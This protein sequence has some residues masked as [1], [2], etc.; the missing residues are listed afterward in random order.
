[1][2]GTVINVAAILAGAGLGVLAGGRLPERVRQTVL[3]CLGLFIVVLGV[4]AAFE[5]FSGPLPD[6]LGRGAVLVVLG[7]LLV[8]G[9]AGEMLDLDGR[10]N[11]LG[12][13]LQARVVRDPAPALTAGGQP[14][15]PVDAELD[16]PDEA[17]GQPVA[18]RFAEGFV[19]ASLV[20]CVGPL[21]ILGPIADG[22]TGDFQL[23]A[24][25]AVLDGFAALAFASALGVGVAFSALPVLLLQGSIALAAAR[26]SG[27]VDDPMMAA[28]TAVGGLLVL[29]IGLRLLDLVHIRLANLVPALFIAPLVVALWP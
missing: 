25:K 16:L 19:L 20:F 4:N 21:A 12:E 27:V 7:A 24:V 6:S 14:C 9:I 23:L 18:S 29:G 10:L 13:R 26:L 15:D 8:G 17:S 5:A 11:R 28:M 22:L 3:H 1:M 2:L